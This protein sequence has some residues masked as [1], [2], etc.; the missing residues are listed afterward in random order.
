MIDI[1]PEAPKFEDSL[2][3]VAA[4]AIERGF[5]G[6]DP[7]DAMNSGFLKDLDNSL[8]RAGFTQL[9]VH[10]PINLRSLFAV[11]QGRNPKGVGLVI[12]ALCK[13]R[14]IGLEF[15]DRILIGLADWLDRTV[16][17]GYSGRCW[18]YNFGWQSGKLFLPRGTPTIVST[19]YIANSLLDLSE[20]TGDGSHA[21]VAR[22]CCDFIVNDLNI[23]EREEGICFS[24]T[25]L[26]SYIV[27]N[28]NVLGA[29]VLA[30]V[31]SRIGNSEFLDLAK[32]AFDFTLH[33][34][35]ENGLWYYSIDA[36]TGLVRSQ[37]D[38]HQGFILDALHDYIIHTRPS[39]SRYERSL[40]RGAAFYRDHQFLE[41]GRGK[42]RYPR[43]WPI[44]I[45]NQAQGI[46]TFSRLSGYDHS[47]LEFA[48]TIADWTIEQM[49]DKKGCF[50]YQQWP[51]F[52]N[53]IPYM[54]WGQAWMMLA[55]STLIKRM[56]A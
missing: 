56:R 22:S 2:G 47:L 27:H 14:S 19:S 46:I 39:D 31:G 37:I 34:Q 45:H 52:T 15:D 6:Y 53:R 54:R 25:P 5:S 40:L 49:Q 11:M 50:Y 38:W 23:T 36:T 41:D 24:Y 3:Q 4:Y 28:A 42:W 12:A 7:Y 32:R 51:R 10:S 13:M 48:K 18:G 33:H 16:S 8:I 20:V 21:D 35:E 1:G 44:D 55:L 26:D 29:A 30:R 43:V 17:P 9:F